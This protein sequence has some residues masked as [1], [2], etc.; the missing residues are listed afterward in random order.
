M[1]LSLA[2]LLCQAR[3][4][5]LAEV[6]CP[7]AE[8]TASAAP[9]DAPDVRQLLQALRDDSFWVRE[10][11]AEALGHSRSPDAIP[12]LLHA[13]QDTTSTVRERAAEALIRMGSEQALTGLL[14]TLGEEKA[15]EILARVGSKEAMDQVHQMRSEQVANRLQQ[16]LRHDLYMQRWHAAQALWK[17]KGAQ[18][19][20]DL[21]QALQE[22][23]PEAKR[24]RP[25]A[26][27]RALFDQPD[28]YTLFEA[29][30]HQHFRTAWDMARDLAQMDPEYAA[31][32]CERVLEAVRETI[33]EK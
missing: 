4:I 5:F 8:P 17:L 21:L 19:I 18:A 28:E 10:R 27:P 2:E 14:K 3:A 16:D 6:G 15:N 24:L 20:D 29:L 1:V 22:A 32:V 9:G 26:S 23:D 31:M 12:G 30:S 13:L 25:G 7:M 33:I 11:A